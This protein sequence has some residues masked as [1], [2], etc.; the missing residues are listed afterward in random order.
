MMEY[1][2]SIEAIV[3]LATGGPLLILAAVVPLA[4]WFAARGRRQ[5]EEGEGEEGHDLE[6][7]DPPAP[8]RRC[9]E[10][11]LPVV[12]IGDGDGGSATPSTVTLP[13]PAA[14]SPTGHHE[15]ISAFFDQRLESFQF[16]RRGSVFGRHSAASGRGSPLSRR[17]D[18]PSSNTAWL[19]SSPPSDVHQ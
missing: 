13:P 17:G 16:L 11:M 9:S 7:Q 8:G 12:L 4:K 18:A 15:D 6:R 19:A 10:S 2:W 5:H 3:A 1:K 14:F